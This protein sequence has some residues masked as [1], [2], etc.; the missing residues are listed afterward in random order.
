[1]LYFLPG[2]VDYTRYPFYYNRL[3]DLG[4]VTVWEQYALYGSVGGFL[5]GSFRPIRKHYFFDKWLKEQD[6]GLKII[7]GARS[8]LTTL[9]LEAGEEY[10]KELQRV[11]RRL[12]VIPLSFFVLESV[13]TGFR[14]YARATA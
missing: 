7:W 6:Q 10:L 9:E 5:K 12:A 2:S 13:L 1:V 4:L 3:K 8:G 14:K 11:P